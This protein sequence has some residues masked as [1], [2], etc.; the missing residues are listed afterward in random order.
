LKQYTDAFQVRDR[1]GRD[2]ALGLRKSVE[3][4]AVQALLDQFIQTH[5]TLDA[6]YAAGLARFD[7]NGGD[8]FEVDRMLSS[9]ERAYRQSG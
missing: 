1:E 3:E 7:A 8:P 6:S 4:P 5:E 2:T 9:D